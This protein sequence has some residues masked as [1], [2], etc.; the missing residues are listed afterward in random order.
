M[1]WRILVAFATAASALAVAPQARAQSSTAQ[2]TA[3]SFASPSPAER[4]KYRWWMPLAY[5]D[6]DELRAEL[7]DMA[8][9]GAGGVEVAPFYV[10]GAGNQS[11]AFLAQYGW[12]TPLW[13]HKL[14]VITDE[15]GKLGLIVDQNLGPQY[16]PTV[17]TLD[18]FNQPE[19]EQQLLFGREFNAAGAARTGTLPAPT[20]APPSVTAKLCGAAAI[21]DTVL[22]VDNLGGFA[23]GDAIT[24]G[25]ERVTV[26]GLGDRT[27]ACADMSVASL[28]A[29]HA[30][31]E[32]AVDAARTTRIK[33]LVAQ[34]AA[35]CTSTTTGSI[36]LVP[37]SVTDVTDK[38]ADGKLDYTFA[39]GNGNPWVVIDLIQ[40]ASGLIAQRGGYTATQPNYV[41]DH[42]N[43]GGVRIQA[44]FWDKSIFTPTVQANLDK[45]GGGSVFEDSLELGSAQKWTWDFLKEFKDLRGYDPTL[46]LPALAGIG[47]QGTGTPAFE[48]AGV[49]PQ[50]RED[51]RQTLSDLYIDRYVRPM[52]QWART[53]GLSFR[54]QPYGTPIAGGVASAAAGIA[55]GESLGMGTLLSSVGPEQGYRA[56]ASGAHFAGENVVSSECCAIFLGNFRSSI[57]G[58][59]VPGMFGEGGDGTQVGGKYSNGLLDSIYKGYAGGVTQTVWHGYAYR[60]APAGV[61]STGRDGG[62][63]PGYHPWDIFGVINV[64]DEFGPRQAS[65]PDYKRVNDVLARTQLALRQGR[66]VVDLGVFYDG[67]PNP[68]LNEAQHFLGTGSATSAAGYTYDYLAPAFLAAATSSAGGYTAG[69]ATGNALI[70]NNQSSMRVADAQHLVAL[71]KQG[72]R[73]FVIGDAPSRTPGASPDSGQLAGAITELLAEP[74]VIRVATEAGLPA[75]L[76]TAGVRPAVA[77]ARSGAAL[78]L[79]RRKAGAVSYDFVYNRSKSVVEDDLTLQG[80]GRPYRLNTWTGAIEPLGTFTAAAGSV[81]VHVRI[82]PND[83]VVLML[84]PEATPTHAVTSTGEV[85]APLI[86]RADHN[87]HYDATLDN[88][89]EVSAD[90]TGLAAAQPL[91]NWTLQAQTWTP[92][93]NQYTT[94][95]TDQAPITLTAGT[96]GKLPSWREITSLTQSS[97]LG[98][99]TTS[100]TLPATWQAADGAY[101]SLGDV[102]D[103]ATVTVNGAEVVVNQSDR[104]RID[105]GRT[106]RAGENTIVIRVATTLF[107]AVRKT[108]DSNYQTADWQRTGLIGP[109]VLTPYRDTALQTSADGGVGGTVPATL[110]LTLAT[111]AAF[112]PFTPG[113]DR[114]YDASTTA[115]VTSTAG[116]A[117]LSVTDPSANS[118]GRLTNGAFTLTEPL[119]AKAASAAFAPLSTAAGAP[120]NLRTYDGPVSND[121]LTIGLRQHITASQALRTG[122]YSKTL[123]FTL[124]TTTP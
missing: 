92:G 16:P 112:G 28:K 91:N 47:V 108:G 19:A 31:G 124:A 55:E 15:A 80:A 107:N 97:G 113:V 54:V 122:A 35:A 17:P 85:L 86:L 118:T 52:Q 56:L 71:A 41:P 100:V 81:T 76:A 1:K 49:G 116:D 50:V 109:V 37:S 96:D 78:G 33:T 5:T 29:A 105:L 104:G 30:V 36:A 39:P 7:R 4:P 38:V 18:S 95:K 94:V 22:K 121:N 65:W 13:A 34:C 70:L 6:D 40:T 57:A 66:S 115:S 61:G 114:A 102:L 26:T 20:T 111:P 12:G 43:R 101:L 98:T 68:S 88:G 32:S 2:L 45:V 99:Y 46:L 8:A 82:A 123:T 60:D 119:Q 74:S 83:A 89:A 44:D 58:P 103:T 51:Y 106:L 64:N 62:T 27:A 73:I 21:G 90:I 9:S 10:P 25:S 59:Q 69:A 53:H 79:L 117:T 23:A 3:M 75:A 77:P 72:L 63:W 11:N 84:K 93:A 48:L 87:G 42:W 67:V 24:V 14:E 120:L 110:S